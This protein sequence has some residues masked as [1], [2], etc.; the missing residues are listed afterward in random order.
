MKIGLD[1]GTPISDYISLKYDKVDFGWSEVGSRIRQ[2][3]TARGLS[4]QALA[5]AAGLTQNA[6]FR[7]EAGESNPQITSLQ[8]V[9]HGLGCSVRELMCGMPAMPEL[10]GRMKRVRAIIESGDGDAIGI[11]DHGIEAAEVLLQRSDRKRS[12]A[13]PTRKLV[14]KGEKQRSSADEVLLNP[15]IKRRRSEADD[16][17]SASGPTTMR[18]GGM[19]FRRSKGKHETR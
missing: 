6:I 4:Q 3:R 9:A 18:V 1:S 15:P 7:I 12:I 2:R 8:R 17:P 16:I 5:T 10:D 13:P 11:L 19:T 14:L